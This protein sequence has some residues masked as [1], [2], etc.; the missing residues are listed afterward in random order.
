VRAAVPDAFSKAQH[1]AVL[2]AIESLTTDGGE[3]VRAVG[4]GLWRVEG[5]RATAEDLV[6]RA[7]HRRCMAGL[8]PIA[9]PEGRG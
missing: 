4:S 7:S 1:E 9:W 8:A 2:T 5:R 3:R 6:K